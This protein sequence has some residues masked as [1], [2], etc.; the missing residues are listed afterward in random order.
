VGSGEQRAKENE[1]LDS[2][3]AIA[4]YL[5]RDVRSVQRWE[6]DR[7][8]PVHR[9]PGEK[10]G[11]VF[12]YT[13]ELENWLHGH[14]A[15]GTSS[16]PSE[17]D[18][19]AGT[20][21]L[22]EASFPIGTELPSAKS[23]YSARRSRNWLW[24]V[25]TAVL[26]I[27]GVAHVSRWVS[28]PA[29]EGS[30]VMLAVLPFLNL[31]R[32]ASRE[33]FIDGLTEEIITDLG[34][35][36]PRALGVIARTSAMKY[37]DTHE[38]IAQ[39]G[40]ELG[41]NYILEGSVRQEGDQARISAQLIQV[42]DQTHVWAQNYE[43]KVEDIL[44]VQRDIAAAIADKIQ[45]N[46]NR[47][48][49]AKLAREQTTNP[50]AFDD[51]LR[52]RYA[53]NRRSMEDFPKAI[54]YFND[55]IKKDPHFVLAY[56]GLADTYT[57]MSLYEMGSPTQLLS[58]A[59]TSALKAV[60][61][62]ENSPAAHTSLA[63]VRVLLDW[64]WVGAESE[65]HHALDLNPNDPP[66]HH[67]YG[68]LVLSALGRHDEAI[69]EL[70]RALEL[71]PFSLVINTDLGYAYHLSRRNN[72]ALAQ[73]QRVVAMDSTFLPVHYDLFM[74]Y[75]TQQQYEAA[76]QEWVIDERLAG[77][78]QVVQE[79]QADYAAGGFRQ[80]MEEGAAEKARTLKSYCGVAE[81]YAFIPEREA[82]LTNLERCYAERDPGLSYLKVDPV[83]DGLRSDPRFKAIEQHLGLE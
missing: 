42:S 7:G 49:W 74:F 16:D 4:A 28:R 83:W 14:P 71:D 6:K 55:A 13:K 34:R 8:L 73:Y 15:N 38:D 5:R 33:Y 2:W 17:N 1:R 3:K 10:G 11:T 21:R 27:I 22:A 20:T 36:N 31:T 68:I 56:A 57:L 77:R 37:K 44:S 80:V 30:R 65:F 51:Y 82:A 24:A 60:A 23:G 32:D 66:T 50:A 9:V 25:V 43:V 69:A 40:R 18:A 53:W 47:G 72:E 75:A 76:M 52:G 79:A 12:A 39:I 35:L 26:A 62:D 63:A 78:P 59:K 48:Q 46:L 54:G 45:I 29:P 61:L 64:D 67:W 19:N 70:R 58:Q 81:M 41:V